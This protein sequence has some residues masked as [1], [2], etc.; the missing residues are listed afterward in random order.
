MTLWWSNTIVTSRRKNKT[1]PL[2]YFSKTHL[3]YSSKL[4]YFN[5]E[6]GNDD[7]EKWPPT[8]VTKRPLKTISEH[9][10]GSQLRKCPI[11]NRVLNTDTYL[12]QRS[13]PQ[14]PYL[15]KE[16]EQCKDGLEKK[17]F[18]HKLHNNVLWTICMH[19]MMH[20]RRRFWTLYILP[21]SI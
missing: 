18:W 13:S 6:G 19:G 15:L 3:E 11:K 21:W 8:K 1:S 17:R 2:S 14:K 16:Q 12:D 4:Q 5:M 7:L 9:A 10:W 20:L